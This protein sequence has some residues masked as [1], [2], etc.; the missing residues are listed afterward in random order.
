[1]I[2]T[3]VRRRTPSVSELQAALLA[4][5]QGAFAACAIRDTAAAAHAGA[6]APVSAVEP[7]PPRTSVAAASGPRQRTWLFGVHGGSGARCLASVLSGTRSSNGSWPA[8]AAGRGRVVLVCRSSH[9]GL[10]A[11]QEYA[12]QFRDR[13]LRQHLDLL[14]VVVTA[15][16]PGRVPPALRRLERLLTGAV[17]LL[18][19]VPWQ[20]AWRLGP[21][22]AYTEPPGWLTTLQHRI[23]AAVPR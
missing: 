16:A 7:V 8:S 12:R 21:P 6:V 22:Q 2:S 13:D 18:G 3:D 14:G 20:P 5:R 23:A 19:E 11:A 17:P 10:S 1:M 9:R 15:A 4:A